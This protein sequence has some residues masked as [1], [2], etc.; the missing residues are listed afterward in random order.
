MH[1]TK[2]IEI[3]LDPA[4]I[5]FWVKVEN[6]PRSGDAT[7]VQIIHSTN[8]LKSSIGFIGTHVKTGDTQIIVS[9][10]CPFWMV[11]SEHRLACYMHEVTASGTHI[12]VASK[13]KTDRV[14]ARNK[15]TATLKEFEETLGIH[16]CMV[17]VYNRNFCGKAQQKFFIKVTG[18][19][20]SFTSGFDVSH[21]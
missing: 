6:Y 4:A 18:P 8:L 21:A 19:T 17:G 13:N 9:S 10:D 14:F 3:G 15:M 16:E 2:I 1:S 11:Y 12:M 7:Y 5:S 20:C